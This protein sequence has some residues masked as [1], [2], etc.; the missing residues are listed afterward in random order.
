MTKGVYTLLV[1]VAES[2]VI[3]VGGLGDTF[4]Q[5]GIWFYVG[6]ALGPSQDSIEH[7]LKRHFSRAKK[8][9]WHIDYLLQSAHVEAAVFAESSEPM[10]CRIS[11]AIQNSGLVVPGPR[12]FGASDCRIGCG[13]HLSRF[14]AKGDPLQM[15][16]TVFMNLGLQPT[17]FR[18]TT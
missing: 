4:I 5:A 15:I 1:K 6:S 17:I 7:R 16:E 13:T 11:K 14:E 12:G 2:L 3:P 9:H 18:D 10:E 8:I